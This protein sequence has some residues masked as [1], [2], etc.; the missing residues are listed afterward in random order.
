ML[1][2]RYNPLTDE[3]IIVSAFT[4]KRPTR[5][6]TT[7]CPICPGGVE[8]PGTYDLV[9][10]DNKYPSLQL[11]PPN[12]V[13][14][15]PILKRKPAK[16]NCEVIVY[17]SNHQSSLSEMPLLQI[18]KL[19]EMWVDRTR[20]LMQY[21]FVKYIFIFE[22]RGQE[23]G[24]SL[25]HPHG[26]L[27]A[28]PF[29]PIR[30][31]RKLDAFEKG[32]EE[33]K[34]CVICK[35]LEEELSKKERIVYENETMI[36]IVPFYA[37]FPYEVHIYPKRHVDSFLYLSGQEKK[38]LAKALK[39]I[40]MKYDRLFNIP[41]PYMMMFFQSPV[42]TKDF[43]RIFHFHVEFNPPKRDKNKIKWMASVETGTWT[44]INPKIP[45]EA[46]QELRNIKVEV[47]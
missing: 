25:E 22:N 34:K 11:N 14:E 47:K 1:E 31:S 39:I 29:I 5:P 9:S 18:E 40:T 26:Q 46:A 4:Q 27:Y 45:E 2:L 12:V 28:F 44:F 41:F 33:H 23:V 20:D 37:R 36:T 19:I 17:T 21:N 35:I 3:W 15:S 30:I 16:G 42:N 6:K 43:S 24:A 13:S 10:F 32:Y 7:E 38:D 8:F